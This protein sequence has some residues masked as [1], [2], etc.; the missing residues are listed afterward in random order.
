MSEIISTY[1]YKLGIKQ[2]QY[3]YSAAIGLFNNIVNLILLLVVN[4][5]SKKL[6]GT[7]LW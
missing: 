7:G 4:K 6:S 1:E 2:G 3:G 5:T